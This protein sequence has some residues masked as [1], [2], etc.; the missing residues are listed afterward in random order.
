ML[1]VKEAE[2]TARLPEV[3]ARAAAGEAVVIE[4]PTRPNLQLTPVAEPERP[5]PHMYSLETSGLTEEAWL[6]F[7]DRHALPTTGIDWVA[8]IRRDRGHTD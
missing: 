6:D 3:L 1:T 8:A 7:W 2:L 4:R 5:P